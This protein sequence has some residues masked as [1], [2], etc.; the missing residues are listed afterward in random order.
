[1]ESNYRPTISVV[2]PV[3]N[4]ENFL[5]NAIQSVLAQ[6]FPALEIVVVDDGSHDR[7]AEIALSFG[8]PVRLIRQKN[9]GVCSA[10][11]KGIQE[12]AG[13]YIALLDHDDLMTPERLEVQIAPMLENASLE[14]TFGQQYYFEEN[15][16]VLA[17]IA[18]GTIDPGKATPAMHCSG[19]VCRR[20]V[21]DRAG[22]FEDG[23]K[24]G[25]FVSW[26]SNATDKGCSYIHLPNIVCCRRIH[27]DNTV[28]N[29][30]MV[31]FT[32]TVK[33][34]LDRRRKEESSRET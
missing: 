29:L 2:I 31:E 14:A 22:W 32:K 23:I 27:S 6:T 1:M 21:F 10:R 26:F 17:E 16:D 30:D 8:A 15:Q 18:A 25:E 9:T 33:G 13:E 20:S 7:T 28:R 3:Y 5:S 4:G 34:I 12:S 11:N 24:M 19:L